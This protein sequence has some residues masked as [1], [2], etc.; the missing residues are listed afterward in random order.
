MNGGSGYECGCR[1]KKGQIGEHRTASGSA[2]F[3]VFLHGALL[4]KTRN[5][6]CRLQ[7]DRNVRAS[8]GTGSFPAYVTV[9]EF[10]SNAYAARRMLQMRYLRS[11]AGAVRPSNH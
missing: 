6:L 5:S 8:A 2:G 9:T 4:S 7:I 10:F 1:I 11:P 3:G